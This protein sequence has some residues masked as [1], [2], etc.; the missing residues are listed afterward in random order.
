MRFEVISKQMKVYTNF[1]FYTKQQQT[2]FL[3][4]IASN[5]GLLQHNKM[6]F[7]PILFV[8]Q[9]IISL[10]LS[11]LDKALVTKDTTILT[12]TSSICG[13]NNEYM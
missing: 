2:E 4:Q 13:N 3:N 9:T 6:F 1:K 8:N 11:E 12:I 7:Y 10:K 5:G